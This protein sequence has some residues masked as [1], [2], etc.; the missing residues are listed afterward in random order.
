MTPMIVKKKIA[1]MQKNFALEPGHLCI[2]LWSVSGKTLLCLGKLDLCTTVD[3]FLSA[4]RQGPRR[5]IIF[6]SRSCKRL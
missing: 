5:P 1:P 4:A 3:N 6:S 2:S